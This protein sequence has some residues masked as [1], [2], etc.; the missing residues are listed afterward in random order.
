MQPHRYPYGSRRTHLELLWRG[1]WKEENMGAP[2]AV[3]RFVLN[4]ALLAAFAPTSSANVLRTDAILRVKGHD[5]QGTRI[6]ITPEFG[7]P[8]DIP[9]SS[10]RFDLEFGLQATYVLRAEHLGCA[11]KEI[12]FDCRVPADVEML[13]FTFPFEIILE[14]FRAG[15]EVF[16]YAHPV[17]AVFFDPAR[18]DFA[19]TTD[20]TRIMKAPVLPELL[21]R[22]NRYIVA[23]PAPIARPTSVS[24][25]DQMQGTLESAHEPGQNYPSVAIDQTETAASEDSLQAMPEIEAE[26][27]DAPVMIESKSV[28]ATHVL[29]EPMLASTLVAHREPRVTNDTTL[30][31]LPLSKRAA[32]DTDIASP[33]AKYTLAGPARDV[34]CGTH[35]SFTAARWIILIDHVPTAD[36]CTELRKVVHAWGGIF[37]FQDGRPSTE[38]MYLKAL[39]GN[40][41]ASDAERFALGHPTID[42][43]PSQP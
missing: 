40:I 12:V 4:A 9:L 32:S 28:I 2:R 10:N 18:E 22:M 21:D 6:T 35:E 27:A 41:R 38:A 17:G 14:R 37:F 7:E 13:E 43:N 36:G 30:V 34:P 8:Y 33:A 15:E 5:W 31:P 23:Q 19:Y 1:S 29:R 42:T 24:L 16:T 39:D 25:A 26:T 20:Y 3:R 11:A